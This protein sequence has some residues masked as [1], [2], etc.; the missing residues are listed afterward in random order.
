MFLLIIIRP[1]YKFSKERTALF[2]L[3]SKSCINCFSQFVLILETIS[4]NIPG[5]RSFFN[6]FFTTPIS[7]FSFNASYFH[8]AGLALN[9]FHSV[10]F[11][12]NYQNLWKLK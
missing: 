7:Q 4:L 1:L 11:L 9:R 3:F 6:A 12:F 8:M 10:Y 2:I 5:N